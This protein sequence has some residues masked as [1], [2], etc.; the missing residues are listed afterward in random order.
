M[1]LKV[2]LLEL[3]AELIRYGVVDPYFKIQHESTAFEY[4]S[5][6]PVEDEM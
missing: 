5:Q 1:K 6:Y 2:V 3:R 4:M